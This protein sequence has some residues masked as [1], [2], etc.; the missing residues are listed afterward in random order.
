MSYVRNFRGAYVWVYSSDYTMVM[1]GVPLLY[2]PLEVVMSKYY[3]ESER[4]LASIFSAGNELP[5]GA[6]VFLDEVGC[7]PSL[8]LCYFWCRTIVRLSVDASCVS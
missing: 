7:N 4:L 6:I 2:V 3:G 1:Q 8:S 5:E